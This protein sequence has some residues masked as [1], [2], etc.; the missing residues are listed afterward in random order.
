VCANLHIDIILVR[1]QL[2]DGFP[3]KLRYRIV[4]GFA[5][6]FT[7]GAVFD[8]LVATFGPAVSVAGPTGGW[9]CF[10]GPVF[11]VRNG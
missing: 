3:F 6:G 7:G 4:A 5:V 9:L 11:G 1:P 10:L 2:F 8:R